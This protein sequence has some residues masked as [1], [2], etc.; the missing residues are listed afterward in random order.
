MK[1][2]RLDPMTNTVDIAHLKWFDGVNVLYDVTTR[3]KQRF[4]NC[5]AT[6]DEFLSRWFAP[7]K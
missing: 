3:N 4:P 1:F 5:I 2:Y 6:E 7:G